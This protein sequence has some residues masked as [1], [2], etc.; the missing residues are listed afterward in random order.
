M[1]YTVEYICDPPMEKSR[2]SINCLGIALP[3]NM[4]KRGLSLGG[5][6]A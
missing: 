5:A 3:G 2:F 4:D 6:G 1:F